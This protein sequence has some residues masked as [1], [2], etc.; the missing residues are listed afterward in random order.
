LL[1]TDYKI[2]AKIITNRPKL[3]FKKAIEEE[4]RVGLKRRQLTDNL[5][6]IRTAII[7]TENSNEKQNKRKQQGRKEETKEIWEKKRQR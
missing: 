1:C 5:N 2:T 4:Q 3:L 7:G 6:S